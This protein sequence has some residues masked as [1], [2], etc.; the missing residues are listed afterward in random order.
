M[1]CLLRL[2]GLLLIAICLAV[3]ARHLAERPAAIPPPAKGE[4][5]TIVRGVRWRSREVAGSGQ[6]PVVFVHGFLSSSATWK[7]VLRQATAGRQA[8]AVDLPGAG[9]SDRPWPYDYS[10]GAQAVALLEFL[11]ARKI[12][13]AILVGSSLGGAVCLIAAAARPD[14]VAGLVLVDSAFPEVT[15]PL[16]FRLLRLPIVGD[17]QIEFLVRPVMAYTLR[18]RLYARAER[19]TEE[20]ISD[21]WNPIPLPGTRRAALA[22]VRSSALGYERLLSKIAAPTLVLW[23]KEDHLLPASD[24]FRLSSQIPGARLIVLPAAGHLPQEEAPEEFS[25][26]A[27]RFLSETVR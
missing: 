20:T 5:D 24:G 8:I 1:G 13:R 17:L 6:L 12:E 25:R 19:V 23:G 2:L 10:A 11:D 22:F 14:R 4:R 15:I 26:V 27:S 21:W 7:K 16:G 3:A 18:H 9:F